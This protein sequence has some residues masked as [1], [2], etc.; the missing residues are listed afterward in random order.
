MLVEDRPGQQWEK[1]NAVPPKADLALRNAFVDALS[2]GEKNSAIAE[3]LGISLST[4]YKWRRCWMEDGDSWLSGKQRTKAKRLPGWSPAQSEQL[5]AA[6]SLEHPKW[7]AAR[8]AKELGARYNCS[9][10][11]GAVHATLAKHGIS[12]R[13]AR[14][15]KL[16]EHH[17]AKRGDGLYVF[18]EAQQELLSLISPFAAWSRGQADTAGFRLVQQRVP[19][20]HAS[21]IGNALLMVIV[22]AFDQRAFAKFNDRPSVNPEGEFLRVV[23]DWYKKRGMVVKEVVTNHG[24]Q[25]SDSYYGNFYEAVLDEFGVKPRFDTF[26]S[27]ALRLNPLVKDVWRDL[28]N[29]LFKERRFD[30]IAAR[31]NHAALNP[32]IQEFL[33]KKFGDG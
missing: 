11:T 3:E 8:L 24:Y 12:T 13:M 32:M 28:Q 2:R 29:Y 26:R 15:R 16:Y 25:Y 33:D 27:G 20:G 17:M 30:A 9:Y 22:D 31:D 18:N 10:S 19:I 4:V 1:R 6:L 7:G 23:L 5:V 14:A 21:P